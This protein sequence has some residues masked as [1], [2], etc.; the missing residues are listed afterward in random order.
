MKEKRNLKAHFKIR[1]GFFE[2]WEFN[3]LNGSFYI[4]SPEKPIEDAIEKLHQIKKRMFHVY[5]GGYKTFYKNCPYSLFIIYY[6]DHSYFEFNNGW[7]LKYVSF[8]SREERDEEYDMLQNLKKSLNKEVT[9]SPKSYY[10]LREEGQKTDNRII[11]FLKSYNPDKLII[12]MRANEIISYI[13]QKSQYAGYP[14]IEVMGF[15]S[16]GKI[17][18]LY[19]EF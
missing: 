18:S 3:L 5:K 2:G 13:G 9:L 7:K 1:K 8:K 15:R 16:N 6:E 14:V 17:I 10:D 12:Q 11:D 19:N 4:Y